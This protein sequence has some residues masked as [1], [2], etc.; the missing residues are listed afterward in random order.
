MPTS[1]LLLPLLPLLPLH[2][3][4]FLVGQ[5]PANTVAQPLA[6][7]NQCAAFAP[8]V[9]LNTNNRKLYNSVTGEYVAVKGVNYYP[10]P[11]AGP[12]TLTNSIDFTTDEFANVWQ[13][14]VA[15]FVQLGVNVVRLYA[16]QPGVS[17]DAFMCALK[18][19][20]IYVIVGLAADCADCAIAKDAA[21]P[22]CYPAAL[23]ERGQFIIAEFARY[24]NVLAFS[25]GN[26]VSL[27]TPSANGG[28]NGVFYNGACQKQFIRDMRQYI[29]DCRNNIR[30][31]PVGLAIADIQRAEKALWYK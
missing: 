8:P 12:L 19:A 30:P 11:N 28:A 18:Q 13:R 1:A 24:D 20:G 16:V 23:R 5:L 2:L 31:I 3:V 6:D 7:F 21:P 26:E 9:V 29:A 27:A 15:R 17:H 14:D 4:L 25:A 10:R 22:A